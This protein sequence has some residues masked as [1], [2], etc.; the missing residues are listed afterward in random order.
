MLGASW[1]H[2]SEAPRA[3]WTHAA[4]AEEPREGGLRSGLE[5][6]NWTWNRTSRCRAARQRR[7][8]GVALSP[9]VS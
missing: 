3:E 5:K 4:G 2:C 1:R 8:L 9:D 7:E 6:W